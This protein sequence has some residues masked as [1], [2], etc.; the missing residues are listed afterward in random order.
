L[1]LSIAKDIDQ[2]NAWLTKSFENLDLSLGV[3]WL[4]V[5]VADDDFESTVSRAVD[6]RRDAL[7]YWDTIFVGSYL[8][9]N[10]VWVI[11]LIVVGILVI[12][13][14]WRR[15]SWATRRVVFLLWRLGEL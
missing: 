9:S 8:K 3:V 10:V 2:G 11:P 6:L 12:P 15:G 4:D 5:V 1:L 7:R 14:R 13:L